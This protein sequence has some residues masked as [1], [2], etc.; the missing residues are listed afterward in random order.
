MTLLE[1]LPV[2]SLALFLAVLLTFLESI[3][4]LTKDVKTIIR[5]TA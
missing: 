5:A 4:H 2:L 1:T 3:K